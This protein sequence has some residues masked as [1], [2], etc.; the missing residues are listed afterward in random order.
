MVLKPLLGKKEARERG[1][2]KCRSIL[3]SRRGMS[4]RGKGNVR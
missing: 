1:I 4:E 3:L 2:L